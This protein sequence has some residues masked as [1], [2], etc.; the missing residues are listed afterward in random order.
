MSEPSGNALFSGK[1]FWHLR[2]DDKSI[3]LEML[4]DEADAK[5]AFGGMP[6]VCE[7]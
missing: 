2:K 1:T 7:R 5:P 6:G 3:S 4:A